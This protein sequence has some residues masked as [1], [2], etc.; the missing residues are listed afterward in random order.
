MSAEVNFEG[1]FVAKEAGFCSGPG[2]TFKPYVPVKM[3][4]HREGLRVTCDNLSQATKLCRNLKTGIEKPC[5]IFFGDLY[6]N[7]TSDTETDLDIHFSSHISGYKN[8]VILYPV[9]NLVTASPFWEDDHPPQK[10]S[11]KV[12]KVLEILIRNQGM[13]IPPGFFCEILWP[14]DSEPK[15]ATTTTLKSYI[16][17]ARK[18]LQDPKDKSRIFTFIR[19]YPRGYAIEK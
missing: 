10:V 17:D 14:H 12:K 16:S 15:S 11:P 8:P 7:V 9:Q 13:V 18:I 5:V 3:V 19:M 6:K 2:G 4:H 1:N